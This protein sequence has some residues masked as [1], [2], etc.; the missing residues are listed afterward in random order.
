[1]FAIHSAD[2]NAQP[3]QGATHEEIESHFAEK[4]IAFM[5]KHFTPELSQALAAQGNSGDIKVFVNRKTS[6]TRN[7]GSRA[8]SLGVAPVVPPDGSG[9]AKTPQ[10]NFGSVAGTIDNSSIAPE[11]SSNWTIFRF[12]LALLII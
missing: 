5:G 10:A 1:G 11:T 9:D 2:P 12:L 6:F 8:L 4:L 7:A 3:I